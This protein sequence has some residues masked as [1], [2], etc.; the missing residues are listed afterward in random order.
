MLNLLPLL[1]IFFIMY[2]FMLRP[3]MKKQKEQTSFLGAVKKGDQ[4]A[5]G[6]GL[7]GRVN[8][9]EDDIVELQLDSKTFIKVLKN[10]ISKEATDSLKNRNI[11]E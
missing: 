10:A 5:T 6:S 11:L 9:L 4:V 2:I 3:Q 7:I 1:A 8:K